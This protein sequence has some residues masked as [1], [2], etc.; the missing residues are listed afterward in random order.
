MC[1]RQG[2]LCGEGGEGP[3]AQPVSCLY[4]TGPDDDAYNLHLVSHGASAMQAPGDKNDFVISCL[5]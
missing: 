4:N 3:M 5:F 2:G 1:I